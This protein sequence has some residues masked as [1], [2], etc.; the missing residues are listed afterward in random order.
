VL[1][2]ALTALELLPLARQLDDFYLGYRKQNPGRIL[3]LR[4]ISTI[5]FPDALG[6]PKEKV[7]YGVRNY[8]EMQIF[9]GASACVVM[10]AGIARVRRSMLVRGA[11]GYLAVA[12]FACGFLIYIGKLPLKILQVT[13]PTLF[14]INFIG[15]MRSVL[16]FLLACV[17][18]VCLQAI[19]DR[20][21]SGRRWLDWATYLG[22][23]LVAFLGYRK[24]YQLAEAT[25]HAEFLRRHAVVP[26][27]VTAGAVV[28]VTAATLLRERW[29]AVAVGAIPVLLAV[30]SVAFANGYLPRIEKSQFYP[31]TATHRY[32]LDHIGRERVATANTVLYPGTTTYYGIR[33]VSAQGF[34]QKTWH[35]MLLRAGSRPL[36]RSPTLPLLLA[37]NEV[38]RS[39][40][41]DRLSAKYWL[42]SPGE[43]TPS[44]LVGG[45][46]AVGVTEL[47]PDRP[48]ELAAPSGAML[49][50]TVGSQEPRLRA[51]RINI[52]RSTTTKD[53]IATVLV[54]LLD[55]TGRVVGD[56]SR[57][58]F[59]D[60]R[61]S[62]GIPVA[63]PSVPVARVRL[64]LRGATRPLPVRADKEGRPALAFEVADHDDGLRI[65]FAHGA[66]VYERLGALPRFRWASRTVVEPDPEQQMR[67][68]VAGLPKDTVLLGAPGG[69]ASG[70]A[71]T[72][73]VQRDT[74]DDIRLRVTA[75]GAGY[76]VVADAMQN[77]W[78]AKLD[79]RP[80]K[81]EAADHAVV[82]VH[83]P[84]GVHTVTY[85][86]APDGWH[87]GLLISA[88]ALLAV[89]AVALRLPALVRRRKR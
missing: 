68:L 84:A 34:H 20:R 82:A 24:V 85:T 35:D 33:S 28:A 27:L 31:V 57:R 86:Y 30:E 25:G 41:L 71:A 56:G 88:L 87:V 63:E 43:P 59:T 4:S 69:E 1:G 55:R 83:V 21:G 89:L 60:S 37:D 23:T 42:T 67:L 16:G 77:G 79:G 48:V 18:A 58:V 80:V 75:A 64:T 19:L 74:G 26:L 9:L 50:H 47:V 40:L 62:F 39:K 13:M 61:K 54:E 45:E 22:A 2:F 76:V 53:Q 7:F 14:G 29:R 3:A 73:D 11:V 51:V 46:Y 15:R 8:A 10:A 66:I 5:A 38:G 65:V 52:R 32:V 44:R 81:L 12:T 6:N 49:R 78:H 70:K 72:V 17:A 36:E